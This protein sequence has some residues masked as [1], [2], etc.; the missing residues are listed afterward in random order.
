MSSNLLKIITYF[1]KYHVLSSML[2]VGE[3]KNRVSCCPKDFEE[4]ST[5]TGGHKCPGS[6]GNQVTARKWNVCVC[7]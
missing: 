7:V 3:K 1:P 5:D 4:N 6:L 2:I